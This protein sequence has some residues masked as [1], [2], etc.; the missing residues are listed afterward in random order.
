MDFTNGKLF[1]TK[2]RREQKKIN[3]EPQ[4]R[5][6]ILRFVPACASKNSSFIAWNLVFVIVFSVSGDITM[7]NLGRSISILFYV[8]GIFD[9]SLIHF[10]LYS[11]R[12]HIFQCCYW[13]GSKDIV[14]SLFLCSSAKYY[15]E[16]YEKRSRGHFTRKNVCIFLLILIL[17]H[18]EFQTM[19]SKWTHT[20]SEVHREIR[21]Q[22]EK[23]L[24]REKETA[25]F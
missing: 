4:P 13:N 11:G 25:I 6:V 3:K 1:Y 8:F 23:K 20:F 17:F 16:Q 7:V 9:F 21:A 10:T 15:C 2:E 14:F 19:I 12:H 18:F 5:L 24:K 22:Q